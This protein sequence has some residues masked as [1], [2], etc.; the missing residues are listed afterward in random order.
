MKTINLTELEK[1]V[2]KGALMEGYIY[3]GTYEE[4]AESHFLCWGFEGKQQ[5]GAAA[6]LVVKGIISVYHEDDGT[7]VYL[8]MPREEAEQLVGGISW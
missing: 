2:L 5:R 4:D 3:D 8:N 1:S 6:S 7:Y